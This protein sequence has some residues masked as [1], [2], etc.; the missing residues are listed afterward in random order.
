MRILHYL[1]EIEVS[2][3]G[4][5]RSV[6][7]LCEALSH[8]GHDVTLLTFEPRDLPA[9]WADRESGVGTP[10]AVAVPWPRFP[11]PVRRFPASTLRRIDPLV[12]DADVL[13]LHVPW[14]GTNVQVARLA[15]RHRKPYLLSTHGMLDRW[16]L[17]RNPV[18]KRVYLRT[19]AR[20]LL[21]G[22]FTAVCTAE[23]ELAE[24]GPHLRCPAVV[25]PL[26]LDLAPFRDLPGPE[27]ARRLVPALATDEPCILSLGRLHEGK[28][29]ES[30]IDA[31]TLLISRGL[32]VRL[33]IAGVGK[34]DYVPGLRERLRRSGI[35]DR[36]A[37]LGGVF[38]R[39]KLS[40]YQACTL[41][42]LPSDHENFGLVAAEAMAAG[43]PVVIS[44]GFQTWR[45]LERGGAMVCP[46]D[47][48]SLAD[49]LAALI[50]DPARR[51]DMSRGGR[52]FVQQWLDPARLLAAYVA[53]YERA[54][55]RGYAP[56]RS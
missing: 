50:R 23:G 56:G 12:N 18:F 2:H 14:E 44:R 8:A 46:T 26:L 19:V 33:L 41:V 39:D 22:A 32:P 51:A 47:A 29:L 7:D 5:V 16:A 1:S 3:G 54:V 42:A 11:K 36:A 31:A 45:E 21:A 6:L 13:H 10:R 43:A 28:G 4:V 15:R 34:D 40:L 9:G 30:L 48:P 49:A 35:G 27:H 38:G 52:L 20:R 53:Q 37:L 25:L 24:S 17:A 55:A